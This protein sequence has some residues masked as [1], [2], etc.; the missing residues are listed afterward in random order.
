M[1]VF[2]EIFPKLPQRTYIPI[3]I[4]N[5]QTFLVYK[6]LTAKSPVEAQ[7]VLGFLHIIAV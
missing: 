4:Y 5:A 1:F 3:T 2:V 7:G 6:T